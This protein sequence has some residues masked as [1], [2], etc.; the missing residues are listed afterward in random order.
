VF[1]GEELSVEADSIC[2]VIDISGSM[3]ELIDGH[4]A[5]DPNGGAGGLIWTGRT[6]LEAAKEE[7]RRSINGLTANFTF[8][9]V[10]YD[11][12]MQVWARTFQRA[13]DFAKADAC[14]WID[15][16]QLGGATGTGPAVGLALGLEPRNRTIV[17][18]TDGAP[19]CGVPP[20]TPD[21][22]R[23]L[24]RSLNVQRATVHV[25]GI[26]AMG[27]MRDFCIGVASDSGGAYHDV[28]R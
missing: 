20:N 10:A 15:H 17:L 16:L 5:P 11:C 21:T 14:L 25:F 26:A 27:P 1:F 22:H 3:C 6:R 18:L 23:E 13:E 19:N 2:Y 8:N 4:W 7:L 9:V 24:I 12:G 28:M